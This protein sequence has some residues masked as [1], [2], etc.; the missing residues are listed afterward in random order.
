MDDVLETAVSPRVYT[1]LPQFPATV[2]DI[3]MEAPAAL[4]NSQIIEA[5]KES[6]NTWLEDVTLFDVYQGE[7]EEAQGRRS[8]AYSLRYRSPER[9]LTDEEVN[10]AHEKI[11]AAL[12]KKLP[13][14]FR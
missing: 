1:P 6:K 4:T 8:L 5:I 10:D 12:A 2:R 3:S 9:T 13:V 7:D 14:T 11:K